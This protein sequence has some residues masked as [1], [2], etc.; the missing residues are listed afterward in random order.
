LRT[1]S[2]NAP[3]VPQ[4]RTDWLIASSIE[5]MPIADMRIG[6]GYEAVRETSIVG[7]TARQFTNHTIGL[8]VRYL[9]AAPAVPLRRTAAR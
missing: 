1:D 3:G 4:D 9:F 5:Y 6:I 2:A 8:R 7:D